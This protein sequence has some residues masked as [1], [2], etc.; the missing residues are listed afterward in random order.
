MRKLFVITIFFIWLFSFSVKTYAISAHS[1]VLL[2]AHSGR[3]LFEKNSKQQLPMASTTKIMTGLLACESNKMD[4]Y[5]KVSP[6][7]SGTEGSSLWLKAGEKLKLQD[8]TYGLMMKSGNDAAVAI[9]EFLAGNTEAFALMM[10]QRAKE[11]GALNTSFK[12]PHGLDDENH[13]TTAFD[14]ALITREAMNNKLFAKI[15]ATKT[16]TI[17]NQNEKWDR[18]LRNH[19]KLLWRF[20]GCVGVKT[21]YTKRCGRC[22]VSYA[23]RDGEELICVTLNAPDDWNDHTYLLNYGFENYNCKNVA[24][25]NDSAYE[26]IYDEKNNRKVKLLYGRNCKIAVGENDK[27][28]TKIQTDKIKI[29]SK[30]GTTAGKITVYC[31]NIPIEEIPLV[32]ASAV[33]NITFFHKIKEVLLYFLKMIASIFSF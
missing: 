10:T 20:D 16:H 31:N 22:L 12:N 4:R 27:I 9:S 26:L 29:P 11:I 5:V 25:K 19:N 3:V 21:G 18:V 30:K 1:A 32:T 7:A 33:K 2:D 28:V 17:P 13:Y 24:K 8:L 14:L 6:F 15:V 23:K